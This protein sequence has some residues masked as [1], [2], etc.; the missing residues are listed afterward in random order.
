MRPILA[1]PALVHPTKTHPRTGEPLVALGVTKRGQLIW[2]VMGASPDDP[3]NGD[4]GQGDGTG[5]TGTPDSSDGGPA[6][7]AGEGDRGFPADTPT[8]EMTDKQQAAYYKHQARKH[9]DRNKA[10]RGAAEKAKKWDDHQAANQT[11]TEK[12]IAEAKAAART[13]ALTEAGSDLVRQLFLAGAKGKLPA[14]KAKTLADGLHAP[15][16]L[17]DNLLPDAE[18]IDTYLTALLPT[19]SAGSGS[20]PDMGQGRRANGKPSGVAAGAAL[21]EERRGKRTGAGITAASNS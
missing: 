13:E 18:K 17:G 14:D 7:G 4:V 20:G 8:A 19:G 21:F 16:F 10:L 3:S 11:D 6:A 15:N 1:D 12:A 9:E 2:P 5:G